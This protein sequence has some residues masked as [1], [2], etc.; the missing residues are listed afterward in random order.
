MRVNKI[1]LDKN[2]LP[3]KVEVSLTLRDVVVLS[4]LLGR[5]SPVKFSDLLPGDENWDALVE[6]YQGLDG[7]V[8]N[9]F[10]DGGLYSA[11]GYLRDG[12]IPDVLF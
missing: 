7:T 3:R 1:S 8:L 11:E 6:L 12:E 2:E 5:M 9:T 10:F 4:N